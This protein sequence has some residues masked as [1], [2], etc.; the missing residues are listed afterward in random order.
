MQKDW[1]CFEMK[2]DGAVIR[3]LLS[4]AERCGGA[5]NLARL[6]G[7]DPSCISRYLRGKVGAV[8]DENWGK[9]KRFLQTAGGEALRGE[10]LPVIEW[11]EFLKDP[12]V[13]GSNGG[14]EELILRAQG[15][16]MAPQI[17]DRDLIV[18]RRLNDLKAAP[19]NKIVVAVFNSLRQLPGRAVCK[20]LR[21]INGGYWF[22]S[23]E[24]QG[25]FF[26]VEHEEILWVGVVLR[27]I[28]E[29]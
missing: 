16:Q 2:L 17:C 7:I 9:L 24:P 29:L 11:R 14:P 6:S 8:S 27:K 19:E 25:I 15:L 26:S 21:K 4:A 3:A 1:Y 5:V 23:D 10:L 28:C 20:R 18:V 22:F 13:V 12:G